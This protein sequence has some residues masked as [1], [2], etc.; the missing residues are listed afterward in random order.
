MPISFCC[1]RTGTSTGRVEG[2]QVQG[3]RVDPLEIDVAIPVD[4]LG[5]LQV[6]VGAVPR[7]VGDLGIEALAA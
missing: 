7:P 1:R 5:V 2:R 3:R 6:P 4:Q